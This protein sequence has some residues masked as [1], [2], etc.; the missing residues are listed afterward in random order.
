[1][2]DRLLVTPHVAAITDVTYRDMCVRT[3]DAAIA[4][5]ERART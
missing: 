4:V 3:A 1:V 2:A 5:L